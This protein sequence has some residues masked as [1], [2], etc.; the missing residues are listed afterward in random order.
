MKSVAVKS[1]GVIRW[2]EVV[3]VRSWFEVIR[4]KLLVWSRWCEVVG[5][6]SL[7]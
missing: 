4:M 1:V 6:K 5:V 3:G 7:V 2:C